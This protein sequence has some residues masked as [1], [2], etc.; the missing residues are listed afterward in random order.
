MTMHTAKVI[1]ID[2]SGGAG[3]IYSEVFRPDPES[4]RIGLQAKRLTGT[5]TLA[6]TLQGGWQ[7]SA[8]GTATDWVDL[9]L[10]T[11]AAI[12]TAQLTPLANTGSG[13]DLFITFPVYRLKGVVASAAA[14][15]VARVVFY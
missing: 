6:L 1:T 3:T 5:G 14:T 4:Q 13:P 10:K 9:D 12:S 2:G 8:V 7:D 11:A 15:G